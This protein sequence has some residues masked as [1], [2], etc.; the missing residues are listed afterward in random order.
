M[1]ARKEKNKM[2]KKDYYIIEKNLNKIYRNEPNNFIDPGTY[3]KIITKLKGINYHTY[4]PYQDSDKVII[5][6]NEL[7][8]IKLIEIISY[9]KLTHR[10]IMGSL[11]GLSIDSELFG[12]IIIT[13]NHY[14]I[15]VIESIYNLIINELNM[16][17]NHNIKLKE[18]SFDILNNYE[19][20]YE[21]ISLIVSSIRIDNVIS[22]IIGTSR[23][24]IKTKF[25]DDEVILNYEVCHKLNYELKENDV[26]S[27]RKHGKYKYIGITKETK[28]NNHLIK[29][30]KYTDN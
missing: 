7:P 14:Y 24:S 1:F 30:L 17:G 3:K 23:E 16:I 2:S 8:K 6:T 18:A 13:N 28:K 19:R 27:I 5:Y 11:F 25:L 29:I 10:E 22:S 9:D 4:Y 20:K 26:F 15:M 21:E 12:D